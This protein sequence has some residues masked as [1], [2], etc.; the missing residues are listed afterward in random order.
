MKLK[1][2][3]KIQ[4]VAGSLTTTIPA[5]ARDLLD[6]KKGDSVEWIIDTKNETITVKKLE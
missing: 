4:S 1:Y 2:N 5:F 3:T 6:L